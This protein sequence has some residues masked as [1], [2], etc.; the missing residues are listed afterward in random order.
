ME[1]G[2]EILLLLFWSE[3]LGLKAHGFDICTS[4]GADSIKRQMKTDIRTYEW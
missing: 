3:T 2:V 4:L 1:L